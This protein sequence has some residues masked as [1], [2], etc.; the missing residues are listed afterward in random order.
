MVSTGDGN[1]VIVTGSGNFDD[2]LNLGGGDDTAYVL[3]AVTPSTDRVAT[4]P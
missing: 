2:T 3:L 1:D 4:T